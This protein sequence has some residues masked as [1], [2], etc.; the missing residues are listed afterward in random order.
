MSKV[1]VSD[2]RQILE[3]EFNLRKL[4]KDDELL[5]MDLYSDLRFDSLDVEELSCEIRKT[6][7]V[8]RT[9]DNEITDTFRNNPTIRNFIELFK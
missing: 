4:P 5:E 6:Y 9:Y 1:K 3:S 7:D 8:S 2:I